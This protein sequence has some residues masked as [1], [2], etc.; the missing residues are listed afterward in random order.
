MSKSFNQFDLVS[1]LR[2]IDYLVGYKGDDGEEIRISGAVLAGLF[3]GMAG[4]SVQIQFSTNAEAWHYPA[5]DNDQYVRF[6]AGDDAWSVAFKIVGED[7]E[8]GEGTDGREVE[9]RESGDMLQWRYVGE[10]AWVDLYDLS[11]L[12]GERGTSIYK[13]NQD[14][15]SP[16]GTGGTVSNYLPL[17]PQGVILKENDILLHSNGII[18]IVT[19][20]GDELHPNGMKFKSML[21]IKGSDGLSAYQTWLA[22]GNTGTEADFLNSLKGENGEG[23]PAGGNEG[24]T[25]MI[26]QD[27]HPVWLRGVK[28]IDLTDYYNG[29]PVYM[30]DG[31]AEKNIII[32]TTE[33]EYLQIVFDYDFKEMRNM[34]IV[35]SN[36]SSVD[37]QISM[38][39]SPNFHVD[40]LG[41]ASLEGLDGLKQGKHIIWTMIPYVSHLTD[42]AIVLV[43]VDFD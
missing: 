8:D 18:S 38:E 21:D 10:D 3:A 13:Y 37:K 7:G 5:M 41:L 33:Q 2:N 29:S 42:V 43:K 16:V 32:D 11:Q 30:I 40:L 39:I 36:A 1:L 14:Y 15:D 19:E 20:V 25:L 24:E 12:Q 17:V 26:N 31:Y 9:L 34:Q 23:L 22:Q 4:K 27:E 6:K 35:M 28:I